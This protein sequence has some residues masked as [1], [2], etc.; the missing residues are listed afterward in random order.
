M[1]CDSSIFD[2]IKRAYETDEKT[3][4]CI[5]NEYVHFKIN[6]AE[7]DYREPEI[8]YETWS[9]RIAT[10]EQKIIPA[11]KTMPRETQEELFREET[12]GEEGITSIEIFKGVA[13]IRKVGAPD[14]FRTFIFT[15]LEEERDKLKLEFIHNYCKDAAEQ[16]VKAAAKCGL[17]SDMTVYNDDYN[18]PH[19]I[20]EIMYCKKRGKRTR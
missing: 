9:E 1:K 14:E 16:I 12:W 2:K 11:I 20:I 18:Y 19:Y 4:L 7:Y 3:H 5:K 13:R 10:E 6:K 8:P 15:K 17:L